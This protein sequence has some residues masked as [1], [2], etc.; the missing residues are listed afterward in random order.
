MRCRC[1]G[2]RGDP[3]VTSTMPFLSVVIPTYNRRDSLLVTLQALKRQHMVDGDFEVIVVS[4]GSTDGTDAMLSKWSGEPL[5]F[6][7]RP[8]FQTNAG[9]A[10]ARNRGVEEACGEVIVFIDDDVEP[11][12]TCLEAHARRHQREDKLVLIGP[13][14]PDPSLEGRESVWIAWEHSMLRKQYESWAKGIWPEETCG[15]HNFYT[16]NAS[17]RRKHVLA[18]GGFD[19]GFT[20]QEDVEL[21][22]R[23][24]RDCG[25]FFRFDAMPAALH[26][27]VRTFESWLRVPYSYGKLDVVRAQRGHAPWSIVGEGYTSRRRAVQRV[28]DLALSAEA[29]GAVVRELLRRTAS[30]FYALPGRPARQAGLVALSGLYKLRYLEGARDQLGSWDAL[31]AVLTRST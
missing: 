8:F 16:G 12:P 23:M 7:L 31:R 27:P 30:V 2:G 4:D 9:P 5:P 20:R 26:R 3:G 13:M 22:A 6:R 28:A 25:V 10:R 21:A 18:V 1:T 24:E 15:A 19:E 11:L 17:V 29:R 14:S